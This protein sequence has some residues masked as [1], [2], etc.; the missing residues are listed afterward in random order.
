MVPF[1]PELTCSTPCVL[2]PKFWNFYRGPKK[3][4]IPF[5][6]TVSK[7]RLGER[8]PNLVSKFKSDKIWPP[9]RPFLG[10]WSGPG[11]VHNDAWYGVKKQ[12][13]CALLFF[14]L[15]SKTMRERDF[16]TSQQIPSG[17][18]LRHFIL[19]LLWSINQRK[20][21]VCLMLGTSVRRNTG[22]LPSNR[23][24]VLYTVKCRPR[25]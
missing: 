19:A 14:S 18:E 6:F 24:I 25:K 16:S 15:S 17:R 5:N 9:F 4:S 12:R 10:K 7:T 2:A 23:G 20:I 21:T 8:I 22:M 13:C 3:F 1:F 11:N